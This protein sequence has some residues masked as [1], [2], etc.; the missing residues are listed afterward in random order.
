MIHIPVVMA[1][2]NNYI[3]L[4]VALTSLIKNVKKD[5]FYDIYILTD[6]TFLTTTETVVKSYLDR[7]KHQFTLSFVRV[8]KC[9]HDVSIKIS[10]ITYPT[11][12]RLMIPEL[13]KEDKC[14][15][16]D[17]DVIVMS[18]LTQL[19]QFSLEGYY[20]AGVRHPGYILSSRKKE[21]CEETLI[22]D[23]EQYIN[24][25]VL[26]MNLKE[27]RKDGVVKKF[28]ELIPRNMTSQDQDIIN[29]VC[30][31]KIAFLPFKYNV[32]TGLSD[33]DIDEYKGIYS[34]EELKEA[35]NEPKI[36]HYL[37]FTKPWNSTRSVFTDY[38]WN[39]CRTIQLFDNIVCDFCKEMLQGA[40]Y[41]SYD[42]D[43][44]TKKVPS[45]F[46]LNYKRKY[47]IYGAGK[48]AKELIAFMKQ[49]G[50][51]PEFILVSDSKNN[52]SEIDRIVVK[53]ISESYDELYDKTI[54][55]GTREKFHREL[56]KNLQQY[57]YLEVLPLSDKWMN[58]VRS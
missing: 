56:I 32:L 42:G 16:L 22:P 8:G 51:I 37:G 18:D 4:V 52:P 55:I 43:M 17:T 5:T 34:E 7:S 19:Y 36:V 20:I 41:H 27:M 50:I 31:G 46:N 58:C 38:W 35:W 30:Y 47:V 44:F 49:K 26:C 53:S 13:L 39:V 11:Y 3:P 14:I 10:H 9:F 28:L 45:I 15:Y 23:I 29:S 54:L 1:T 12:F 6:D 40:I 2:D 24:A 57:D 33:M 48:V 25:G 21:I